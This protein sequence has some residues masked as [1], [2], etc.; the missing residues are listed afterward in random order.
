MFCKT[1]GKRIDAN[2]V[3]CCHCGCATD[4]IIK[5]YYAKD[6]NKRALGVLL[7]FIFGLIGLIM[8][9]LMYERGSEERATFKKGWV[10]GF[11]T[12]I[13][14]GVIIGVIYATFAV[15]GILITIIPSLPI[16]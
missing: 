13:V 1:C 6:R 12:Q 16:F 10:E 5:P 3:I 8:G 9:L 11:I 2:A 15:I 14:L 4:N 7:S